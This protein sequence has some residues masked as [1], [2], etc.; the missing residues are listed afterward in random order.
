MVHPQ[1]DQRWAIIKLALAT[2]LLLLLAMSLSCAILPDFYPG[3]D[4]LQFD[5]RL[6]LTS[7]ST[8]TSNETSTDNI[9]GEKKNHCFCLQGHDCDVHWENRR[10][11]IGGSLMCADADN[12]I[13]GVTSSRSALLDKLYAFILPPV[14]RWDAAR[15]LTLSVDP[16]ARYPPT[17]LLLPLCE[18]D[19]QS[20]DQTTC[21]NNNQSITNNDDE[22]IFHSSEQAHAF[23]PLLP[24]VIRYMA[25]LLVYVMPSQILPSTYEATAALSAILINMIAF[26]IAALSLY[27]MTKSLLLRVALEK[28]QNT[29]QRNANDGFQRYEALAMTTARLFCINPAGVFFT[30]AYSESI[31]A[32]LT[33]A[34]HA[35]VAKGVY[36]RYLLNTIGR[37]DYSREEV[38]LWNAYICVLWVTSTVMWML[39]SYTRSNGTFS[40]IW[41]MLIGISQCCLYLTNQNSNTPESFSKCRKSLVSCCLFALGVVIPVLYHDRRGYNFHCNATD[42]MTQQTNPMP[43][44]CDHGSHGGLG[45]SMYA[46]VQRKHWNVGLFRYYELKQIPNFIL[47]FPV[48]AL[49]FGA[50]AFWIRCSW[51]RHIGPREMNTRKGSALQYIF[52]MLQNVFSWSF[53]ALAVYSYDSDPR[54]KITSSEGADIPS[55]VLLGPNFLSYYAILAGFAIVGAFLAHVQIATRLICSSCPALYWFCATLLA[56]SAEIKGNVK[57]RSEWWISLTPLLLYGYFALYNILGVIMHVNW[58]PWT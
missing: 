36:Y 10:Q 22:T 21:T 47:A 1:N 45:F 55:M 33:F 12:N 39:A 18:G 49:C 5:L 7:F 23:F 3:D 11:F 4:V 30:T 28:K 24:L 25:N 26:A 8:P 16:W 32:M 15:F 20:N 40:S 51:N 29:T 56:R 52:C 43:S 58:L 54:N 27:E 37:T 6:A 31:F 53:Q 41:W 19:N 35:I 34:G 13:Q 14:T 50:A 48:L 44:W 38:Q 46:L 2:R 42:S 17:H 57:S 9:T